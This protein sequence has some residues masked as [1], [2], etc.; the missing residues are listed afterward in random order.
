MRESVY[1]MYDGKS[2]KDFGVFLGGTNSGLYEETFLPNRKI[3]EKKVA[4]REKP[5]FQGVEHDPLSFSLSFVLEEWHDRNNLR[6]IARW[7]FQP[8]YKP[9]ILDSNPNR[10]FYAIV[11]GSSSL[12]HN[13]AKDGYVELNIRCDSPYSYTHE[14][15]LLNVEYI[16]ANNSTF[17]SNDISNFDNGTHNNTITTA[18]GLTAESTVD[19]WGILY[20]S[21]QKWGSIT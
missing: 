21:H 3:I 11:E 14:Y 10:I 6:E 1:F 16:D 19:T 2:S 17:V 7:L 18:N 4:G 5:Y 15:N 9:L 12:L 20:A 8:Y 13:G